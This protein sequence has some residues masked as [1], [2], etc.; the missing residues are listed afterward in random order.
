MSEE[1]ILSRLEYN[2]R[3][4]PGLPLRVVD[5]L[6]T[7]MTP[8]RYANLVGKQRSFLDTLETLDGVVQYHP[9]LTEPQRLEVRDLIE[10]A[11]TEET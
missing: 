11:I 4:V 10:A 2:V 3:D 5:E 8:S 9:H 1:S 6:L 7:G